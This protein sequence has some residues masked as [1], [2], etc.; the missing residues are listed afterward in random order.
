MWNKGVLRIKLG[1]TWIS[2][3]TSLFSVIFVKI[4]MGSSFDVAKIYYCAVFRNLRLV[5]V[6]TC[7]SLNG[8]FFFQP[9]LVVFGLKCELCLT[10]T[11]YSPSVVWA[12]LSRLLYSPFFYICKAKSALIINDAP[13]Y[14]PHS[15]HNIWSVFCLYIL[16]RT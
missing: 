8:Y 14:I 9:F 10:K 16:C 4:A 3:Q 15:D 6:R 1:S 11:K 5:Q 12:V 13:S 2:A 7:P